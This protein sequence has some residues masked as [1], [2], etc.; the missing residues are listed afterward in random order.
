MR[1]KER[2]GGDGRRRRRRRRRRRT[3]MTS[4]VSCITTDY[5]MGADME[6]TVWYVKKGSGEDA[7]CPSVR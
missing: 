6:G 7:L 1:Q 5:D 4:R 2:Q 3:T